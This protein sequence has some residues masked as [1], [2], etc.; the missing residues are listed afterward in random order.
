[1]L[2]GGVGGIGRGEAVLPATALILYNLFF[3]IFEQ[4]HLHFRTFSE[5]YLGNI[6]VW[7]VSVD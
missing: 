4:K 6:F 5:N 7:S 3:L 1:M 2:E